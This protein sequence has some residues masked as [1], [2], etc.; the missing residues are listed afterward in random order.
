M[1]AGGSIFGAPDIAGFS[2]TVRKV[3]R[4]VNRVSIPSDLI[5]RIFAEYG[6][7]LFGFDL[8]HGLQALRS[9]N[10][11]RFENEGFDN[12]VIRVVLETGA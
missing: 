11:F 7:V 5:N 1:I 9:K 12:E 10:C 8:I 2:R 6:R 4:A 3:T